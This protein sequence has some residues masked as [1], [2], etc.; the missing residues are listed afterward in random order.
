MS[1]TPFHKNSFKLDHKLQQQV[2]VNRKAKIKQA[3]E[4]RDKKEKDT[5]KSK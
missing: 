4:K 2:A 1:F 3:K 5:K